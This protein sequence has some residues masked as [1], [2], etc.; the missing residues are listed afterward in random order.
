MDEILLGQCKGQ[1][2]QQGSP[3]PDIQD[4]EAPRSIHRQMFV[5]TTNLNAPLWPDLEHLKNH[6][7]LASLTNNW[8]AHYRK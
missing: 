3:T 8:C 4:L 1:A 7:L 2:C 5:T 6:S